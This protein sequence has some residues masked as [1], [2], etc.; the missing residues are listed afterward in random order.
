MSLKICLTEK[1]MWSAKLHG[2][3]HFHSVFKIF[4]LCVGRKSNKAAALL[5]LFLYWH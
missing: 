3:R 4:L 1:E 2:C 5:L